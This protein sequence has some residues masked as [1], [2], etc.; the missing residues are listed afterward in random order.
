MGELSCEF[1]ALVTVDTPHEWCPW[2][3]Y[4]EKAVVS[5]TPLLTHYHASL[6]A[7]EIKQLR[8]IALYEDDSWF[9]VAGNCDGVFYNNHSPELF[10]VDENGH[11]LPT[12]ETGTGRITLQCGEYSFEV[13]VTVEP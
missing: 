7:R 1:R 8:G 4:P 12:G 3:P 13:S 6:A 2:Q 10:D 9:E 11:V 5:F